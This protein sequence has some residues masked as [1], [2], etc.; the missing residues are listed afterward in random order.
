MFVLFSVL[1]LLDLSHFKVERQSQFVG[2]IGLRDKA[3]TNLLQNTVQDKSE[4]LQ[5]LHRVVKLVAFNK[6]WRWFYGQRDS[7]QEV[8]KDLN[9]R[10]NPD[11][12]VKSYSFSSNFPEDMQRLK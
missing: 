2:R 3:V 10:F 12:T 5:S 11:G 6:I 8:S 1:P 9:I 7:G 4:R